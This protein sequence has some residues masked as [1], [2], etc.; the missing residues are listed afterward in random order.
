MKEK[1]FRDPTIPLSVL[2]STHPFF[3]SVRPRGPRPLTKAP[4]LKPEPRA[5]MIT[6]NPLLINAT[7]EVESSIRLP[8][9]PQFPAR[10][11][12][13]FDEYKVKR[14]GKS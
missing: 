2:L 11:V 7:A 8:L 9:S 4:L 6:L 5:V 14:E 13:A 3:P 12:P 10:L 1:S